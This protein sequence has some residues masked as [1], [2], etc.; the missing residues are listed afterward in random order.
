M[1]T[2]RRV[3]KEYYAHTALWGGQG[4]CKIQL[5]GDFFSSG[6][7]RKKKK[8]KP[9]QS[10]HVR[11]KGTNLVY[12][13]YNNDIPAVI[14]FFRHFRVIHQLATCTSTMCIR[15]YRYARRKNVENKIKYNQGG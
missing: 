8:I 3:T 1:E 11:P 10:V 9:T 13:T 5:A 4:G 14:L 7:A 12:K 15:T 2:K 6:R